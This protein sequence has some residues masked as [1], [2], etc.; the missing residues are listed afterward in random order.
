M[1]SVYWP[2]LG[3]AGPCARPWPWRHR[4][5]SA[6]MPPGRFGLAVGRPSV[7]DVMT[8]GAPKALRDAVRAEQVRLLYSDHGMALASTWVVSLLLSG[9]LVW[10]KTLAPVAAGVF[11]AFMTLHTA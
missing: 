3:A 4:G 11:L 8:P 2:S 1:D 9:L 6:K 5:K 10:E 7:T